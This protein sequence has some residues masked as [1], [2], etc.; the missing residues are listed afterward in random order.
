MEKLL[1]KVWKS[2]VA[3]YTRTHQSS[4]VYKWSWAWRARVIIGEFWDITEWD[5]NSHSDVESILYLPDGCTGGRSISQPV[6][7]RW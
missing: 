7:I 5:H 4:Y 6:T 3:N 1:S 2:G